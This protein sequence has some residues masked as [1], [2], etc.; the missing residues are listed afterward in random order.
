VRGKDDLRVDGLEPIK[1][2]ERNLTVVVEAMEC[3]EA[4]PARPK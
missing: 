3:E 4:D 1:R 2:G